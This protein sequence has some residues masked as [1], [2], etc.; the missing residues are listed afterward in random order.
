MT[1]GLPFGLFSFRFW[2][3]FAIPASLLAA[4]ATW[5][6]LVNLKKFNIPK[7][8]VFAVIILGVLF[9]SAY[10]KYAVNTAGWGFGIGWTSQDELAGYYWMQQN[11]PVDTKVFAFTGNIFVMGYDMYSCVWCSDVINFQK[12]AF[13]D[14]VSNLHTWLRQNGYQYIVVGGRDVKQFGLNETNAKLQAL[15]SSGLFTLAE[16]TNGAFVFKVQ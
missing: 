4:E 15:S 2:M 8:L 13:N 6:L 16:K 12:T 10:Q 9:T 11:L 14:S 1:F 5:W 7:I 3:L